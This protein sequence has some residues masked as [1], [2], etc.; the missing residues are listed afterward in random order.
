MGGKPSNVSTSATKIDAFQLQRS[1][2]GLVIPVGWGRSRLTPNLLW[3]SAFVATAITTTTKSGGKGGA[4][5]SVKQTSTTYVYSASVIMGIEEGTITGIR[6]VYKDKMVYVD[7]ATTALQQAGLSLASGGVA[8]AGWAYLSTTYPSEYLNYSE[9]A[10]VYA[11]AYGL[12]DSATLQN[13]SFEVDH[14]SQVSGLPD[15]NPKD[16]VQDF[17]ENTRYGVPQWSSALTGTLT[18]FSDYCLAN[19][20]L[21]SPLL[22]TQRSGREILS[23]WM[24]ATNS[25]NYWSEGVLKFRPYGDTAATGNGATFTPNLTP[26]YALTDEEFLGEEPVIFS[27]S[28][29]ADAKNKVFIEFLDR[30]HQYAVS[31]MPAND[32]AS[33]EELGALPEKVLSLHCICEPSIART[34]AQLRLQRLQYV[35]GKYSF[36]LPWAYVLLECMD[37]V[38]LTTTSCGGL[39]SLLV[40]IKRITEDED[41]CFDIEA[42]PVQ[43]GTAAAA[44]YGSGSTYGA[45]V[46]Q[47]VSPGNVATPYIFV[48][49]SSLSGGM[50]EMWCAVAGAS[51][52]VWGGCEVWA[53]LTDYNYVKIG[54]IPVPSRY[55]VTTTA[56]ASA[57]DPD[58]VNT[59]GV[60]LTIS[61]G[62]VVFASQSEVDAELTPCLLDDEVIGFRDANLTTAYNYNM[63]YL[64]RARLGTSQAAHLTGAQFVRLDDAIFKFGFD[65][66][67]LGQTMYIKFLSYNVYGDGL[68]NLADV[69]PYTVVLDTNLLAPK[70]GSFTAVGSTVTGPSGG[71]QPVLA[72]TGTVPLGLLVD[73]VVLEYNLTGTD[74]W[75]DAGEAPP[76]VTDRNIGG[77]ADATSYYVAVSFKTGGRTGPRLIIGPVTTGTL[78][79]SGGPITDGYVVLDTTTTGA[80]STTSPATGHLEVE[81]WGVGGDSG[82]A[83]ATYTTDPKTGDPTISGYTPSGGGGGGGYSYKK[84]AVT[85][86]DAYAGVVGA[87][88]ANTTC[89]TTGQTAGPGGDGSAGGGGTVQGTAG[90]AS[91]GTTNTSGRAGGLTNVWDGGSAGN[92]AGDQTAG[93]SPGT[94]PGGGASGPSQIG[95]PARVRVTWRT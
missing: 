42:E 31:V 41:G 22:D 71:K 43:V 16:C 3:Y 32:M 4:T 60:N 92:G 27:E 80:W 45:T 37:L 61:H 39:S 74:P 28:S 81:L 48:P 50:L 63:V 35:T 89:T 18:E 9:I 23:D 64:R 25:E 19:N 6:A 90:S 33:I 56:L 87:H 34:V 66:V 88:A 47:A 95:A 38:T 55:G 76:S 17:L 26:V 46:N 70:P 2:N 7:G 93:G 5:G 12:S 11:S 20:L 68:Q 59:L 83:Y 78:A 77:V 58:N 40:R 72:V 84:P 1:S 85:L 8:Q 51:P 30:N 54:T 86:G 67:S 10:Y 29:P 79:V 65:E 49:P 94:P 21:L 14:R 75:V 44:T 24:I 15:A 52:S 13:H 69:S 36:K 82:A 57:S 62:I 73:S 53:S 91:G